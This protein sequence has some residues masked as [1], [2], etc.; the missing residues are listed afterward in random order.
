[1]THS[2]LFEAAGILA[3]ILHEYSRALAGPLSALESLA[4]SGVWITTPLLRKIPIA[5]NGLRDYGR[6][7]VSFRAS[8]EF[9]QYPG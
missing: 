9:M 7:P 6:S 8:R 5:N 4:Q 1:M 2:H 3:R